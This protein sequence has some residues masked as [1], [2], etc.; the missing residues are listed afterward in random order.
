MSLVDRKQLCYIGWRKEILWY[1][2]GLN[3]LKLEQLHLGF[4]FVA[5]IQ[6]PEKFSFKFRESSS[7]DL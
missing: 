6:K 7:I 3:T 5:E 4:R 1:M 2:R